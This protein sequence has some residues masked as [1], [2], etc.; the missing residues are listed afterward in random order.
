MVKKSGARL[1]AEIIN[2]YEVNHVFYVPTILMST[3]AE[4]DDLSVKKIMTHGEKAAAY[5]ADGYARASG[6]VGICMAQQIGSSNLAAGLRDAYMACSPVLAIT[7]G[8]VIESRYKNAYQ[9]VEDINQFDCVTKFNAE[10]NHIDRLPDLMRQ[11][12]RSATS[13]TPGPVHLRLSGLHGGHIESMPTDLVPVFEDH[14]I[15]VPAFRTKP[16]NFLIVRALEHLMSAKKPLIV[17]GGGIISSKAENE[18]VDFVEKLNIPVATSLNAKAVIVDNHPLSV[19]VLG[20]YSRSCANKIASEADLIF[21]IGSHTGGQVTA[22]WKLINKNAKIIQLDINPEE[23]GRNYPNTVSLNG[24]IKVS[25]LQMLE[26]LR[27]GNSQDIKEWLNRTKFLVKE[28][29]TYFEPLLTSESLPLRPERICREIS[30]S[31]PE[32][33]V[34]VSDTGHAGMWTSQ[35]IELKSPNQKFIRCAGS[36]GWGLPGAIGVKCAL[37]NNPVVCFTG[38]GGIY[39]HLSELETASRFGINIVV[40][41]NNNS[42]LNQEI[43][44]VKAAYSGKNATLSGEIWRFSKSIDFSKLAQDLGCV[45]F[46]I[47]NPGQLK[48]ILPEALKMNRPVVID[49]VS[50]ENALAPTA[51]IPGGV[52]TY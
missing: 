51:W 40:I 29:R 34:L 26:N 49:V 9:E 31:L 2:G 28:W 21:F 23:L 35:M 14:F 1:I 6:K 47:E 45:G 30:E 15:K 16:E 27:G 46:R 19:G 44:L 7:G 41:V 48:K 22:N 39:Y 13:G 38:D 18:L 17:A 10:V 37:P 4:F 36:L 32:N 42:S 50:D 33:G 43:P 8:S 3:L 12:F 11:A 5:M 20:T 24:D 52:A 25:L